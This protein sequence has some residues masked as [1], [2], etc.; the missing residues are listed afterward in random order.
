MLDQFLLVLEEC[1]EEVEEQ[2]MPLKSFVWLHP[3]AKM[4]DEQVAAMAQW[5]QQTYR[6]QRQ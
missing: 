6:S 1:F 3:E 4:A 2:H 5:F